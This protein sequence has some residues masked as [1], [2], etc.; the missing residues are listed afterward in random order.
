MLTSSGLVI[1]LFWLGL[2]VSLSYADMQMIL[3]TNTQTFG[4]LLGII[5]AGLMFTQGKFSELT[6][7]LTEKSPEYL[8]QV[9]SIAKIHP[10]ETRLFALKKAFTQLADS[11]TIAEEKNLYERISTKASSIFVDFAVLLNL[12]LKQEGVADSRFLVSEMDPNFYKAYQ[13]TIQSVRKEW[14]IFTI[15]KR[16]VDT[17]ETRTTFSSRKSNREPPLQV[18]LKSSIP[19]LKLKENVD[20]INKNIRTEAN[21]TYNELDKELGEISKRINSIKKVINKNI[22]FIFNEYLSFYPY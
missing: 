13:K 18:D 15:I 1:I 20:K 2:T 6:S 7:K 10:I 19:V 9:L 8:T 4:T 3:T 17:W 12:K 22:F 14:Q 5:T 16:I 21:K 11:T